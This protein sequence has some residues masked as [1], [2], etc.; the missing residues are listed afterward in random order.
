MDEEEV[1]LAINHKEVGENFA[2]KLDWQASTSL[3][4]FEHDTVVGHLRKANSSIPQPFKDYEYNA[5]VISIDQR[6]NGN[7]PSSVSE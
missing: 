3:L 5:T 7:V 6:A 4:L 1:F 2:L